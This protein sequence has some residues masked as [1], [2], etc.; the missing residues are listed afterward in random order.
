RWA[1]TYR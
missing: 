1:T